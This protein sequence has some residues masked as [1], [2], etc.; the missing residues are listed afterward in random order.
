MYLY[1]SFLE[2]YSSAFIFTLS[3]DSIL[4]QLLDFR[5]PSALHCGSPRFEHGTDH[6]LLAHL[7]SREAYTRKR[8]F[9]IMQR[10]DD[11]SRLCRLEFAQGAANRLFGV[12]RPRETGRC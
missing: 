11:F 5:L 6:D 9:N 1:Y 12:L 4:N 2:W 8:H 10:K 7:L 3:E